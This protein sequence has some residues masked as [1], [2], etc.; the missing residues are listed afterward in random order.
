VATLSLGA[1]ST[2]FLRMK[3]KYF[4]GLHQTGNVVNILKDDP[5]LPGCLLYDS[6][7]ALKER[8]EQGSLT[9]HEYDEERHKILKSSADSFPPIKMELH[10]GHMVV[11]HG[12]N[13]QK[14]YE[15]GFLFN[16]LVHIVKLLTFI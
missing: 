15:V 8:Y 5:V 4:T 16:F 11:M 6:R 2:M 3:T 12:G 1:T 7:K 9:E 10:H 14:Y 13:L